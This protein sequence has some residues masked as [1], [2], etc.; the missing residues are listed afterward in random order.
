MATVGTT[1][2]PAY[3]YDAQTDTWIPVGVGPHSH[4]NFVESTV[5]DAKGDLLAGTAP[6]TVGRLGVGTNG[7]Y[8][9]ADSSA[10]TGLVWSTVD[11]LPTQTGNTGKYLTTNGSAASW[12]DIITDPTSDIFMMMGA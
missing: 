9:K 12:A 6:D 11:A 3:V 1:P 2:R 7:Q 10:A 8:L 4:A 5:V